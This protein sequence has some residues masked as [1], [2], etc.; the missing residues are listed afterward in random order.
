MMAGQCGELVQVAAKKL[1]YLDTDSHPDGERSLKIRLEEEIADV[2]AAT[3]FVEH[4][5]GL[6][7]QAILIRRDAK[8]NLF[9]EWHRDPDNGLTIICSCPTECDCLCYP[10]STSTECPIHNDN[11]DPALDCPVHGESSAD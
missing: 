2:I 10:H 11:P 1:A 3:S 6:D 4:I 5:F 9:F 8:L 7:L